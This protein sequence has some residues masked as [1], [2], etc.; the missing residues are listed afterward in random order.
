MRWKTLLLST[1]VLVVSLSKTSFLASWSALLLMQFVSLQVVMVMHIF[2]Q[3]M[4]WVAT[5]LLQWLAI[6]KALILQ[7]LHLFRFTLHVF[8]FMVISSLNLPLCRNLCVTMDVS[9]FQRISKMQRNCRQ[10]LFR[11]KIFLKKIAII[12]WSVVILPLETL[13]LV[14]LHHVQLR[15]VVTKA[16]V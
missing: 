14:T 7:T 2:F 16:L 4:Q 11:A 9:G 8:L 13:Y 3:R 5:V 10:V 12:I 1:V 6:A 15:N